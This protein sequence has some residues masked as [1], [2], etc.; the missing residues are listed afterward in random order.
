MF[1][2]IRGLRCDESR[3]AVNVCGTMVGVSSSLMAMVAQNR[4]RLVTHLTYMVYFHA[5]QLAFIMPLYISAVYGL[6]PFL[7]WNKG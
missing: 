7:L 1:V 4:N 6:T 3:L 5:H 2:L